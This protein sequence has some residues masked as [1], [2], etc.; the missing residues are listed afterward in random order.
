MLFSLG[1]T[2]KTVIKLCGE[3]CLKC[4]ERHV[5]LAEFHAADEV[6][7]TG[8]MGELTPVNE[9]D[10]RDIGNGSYPITKMI[11]EEYTKLTKQP[12]FSHEIPEFTV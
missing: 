4:V 11:Q 2:R 1:I 10:G 12:D 3:L 6:F 9:I 7:T 5:S 8:T